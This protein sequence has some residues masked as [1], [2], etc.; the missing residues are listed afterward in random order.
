MSRP[1]T[2]QVIER[3]GKRGR[4]F[5]LRFRAYGRRRY[6]TLGTRDEGWTPAKAE[7]E[8]ENVLADVRRGIWRAPESVVAATEPEPEQTFHEFASR[9]LAAREKEGLR[10]RTIEDYRW[11]LTHHL[12]PFFAS[13]RLS[14]ITKRDVDDYKTLKASEGRLAA[15]QINKT[16]TRLSQ[17]LALAEEY[18]LISGNPAAGKRR[19]LPRTKPRRGWVRPEQLMPLLEAADGLLGGRGRPLLATMA[20]AGG[21]RVSEV[22]AIERRHVN[23]AR[24]TLELEQA[25]TDA[26]IRTIDLTPALRDELA[27]W[28]DRS[29]F[30]AP[31]DRV[32][33]TLNGKPD[34][35]HNVNKRLLAKAIEKANTRLAELG[36]EP[37]GH[38][39]PHGLRRTFAS[40]RHAAGDDVAYTS[41]QLGHESPSFTLTVY[42]QETKR[43]ERLTT[44]ERREYDHAV[45]W[46]QW[47]R[48]GTKDLDALSAVAASENGS[49]RDAASDAELNEWSVPGSNR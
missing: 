35:R 33:P 31:N 46:A 27:F 25:K 45:E 3:R 14:E 32:F 10:P 40:L 38:V 34:N 21:L 29:P 26:G 22:L 47:A 16:L 37:I 17:I 7:L 42:V 8:L 48:M 39:T 24:G 28:L 49:Q 23:L 9:W 43:R 30:K 18:E 4:T 19:R 41:A 13:Y 20:G 5:A 6:L 12:L 44:A 36:I 11:A 2:G 15:N 1:A